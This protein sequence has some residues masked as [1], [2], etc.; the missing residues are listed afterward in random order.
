MQA[1]RGRQEGSQSRTRVSASVPGELWAGNCFRPFLSVLA[2]VS[3]CQPVCVCFLL[4]VSSRA[5]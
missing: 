3:P 2:R 1:E 4:P 5:R